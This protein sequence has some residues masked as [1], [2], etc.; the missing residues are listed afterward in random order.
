MATIGISPEVGVVT[1]VEELVHRVSALDVD[2][3]LE[4]KGTTESR[5]PSRLRAL[6]AGGA[7]YDFRLCRSIIDT[8]HS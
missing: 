5:E 2:I 6:G 4:V 7:R 3:E 1:L 8:A